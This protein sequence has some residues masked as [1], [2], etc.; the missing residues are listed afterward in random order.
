MAHSADLLGPGTGYGGQGTPPAPSTPSVP[1]APPPPPGRPLPEFDA[2]PVRGPDWSG[3]KAAGRLLADARDTGAVPVVD[4]GADG[5]DPTVPAGPASARRTTGSTPV[6]RVA[7]G[8]VA[9]AR[10]RALAGAAEALRA[11]GA[12]DTAVRPGPSAPGAGIAGTAG[13]VGWGARLPVRRKPRRSATPAENPPGLHDDGAVP[14]AAPTVLLAPPAPHPTT[15]FRPGPGPVTDPHGPGNGSGDRPDG[16]DGPAEGTDKPGRLDRR[17]MLLAGA[18]VTGLA[19]VGLYTTDRVL[20]GK[21]ASSTRPAAKRAKDG[22]A[23]ADR[24]ESFARTATPAPPSEPQPTSLYDSA[25]EAA[26]ATEVTV[27]TILATDDP[28]LHLLRRAT[29]GPT[30]A[31]VD[32]VHDMGIDAWLEQQLDPQS[33]DDGMAD[34]VWAKLPLASKSPGEIQ[35]SI[36][37]YS[38]DAMFD[39]GRATLGR[40]AWSQRQLYEVMVD[41][42]ADHLHVPVPGGAAWDVGNAY[43]SGIIREHALGS[44]KDMLLAAMQH[45]AMLR[46]LSNTESDKDAVNENLGRE[47]LELHTVGVGSGYTEDDVRNSAYI[48][49]GRTEISQYDAEQ[50]R[51]QAGTFV[52]DPGK[53]WTGAVKVMDFQH[54]NGSE[55]EGLDVGDAY[56]TYLASHPST[57]RTI[58]RKLVVRF[59]SDDPPDSLVDRLATAFVDN[60]TAIKPVL[61][62]LFRSAEF[63]AA[64]GQKTRRPLENLIASLRAV[65]AQPGTDPATALDGLY[66]WTHDM[67]HQPLAW[68]APNGYADVHA[69]WRSAGGLLHTW[70][71]HLGLMQDWINGLGD[72]QSDQLIGDRPQA[73]VGEYVDSLCQRLCLQTFQAPHRDGLLA[74]VGADQATPTGQSGLH[75]VLDHLAGLVLDSAYFALR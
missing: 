72:I 50:G 60:D 48:L 25:S 11:G 41:F 37:Q 67:G 30:P 28:A 9:P 32:Q 21:P 55:N 16:P 75:D 35:R 22:G 27:P 65:D 64:V 53:H 33:I 1:Q 46:Y 58:A 31:M 17:R 38:W 24:D 66:W 18:A 5:D 26:E 8:A 6:T 45:P 29:F 3:W 49:T 74:F 20:G 23:F 61:D 19:G 40:Q 4:L 44:F 71:F 62:V 43:Y 10:R 15:G 59:V 36:E 13:R 52:Y 70:R 2:T 68:P 56:L 39:Y 51:G 14:P 69:A 34:G 57:A 54:A 73:T 7:P 42:W 63:W 47:L 12:A